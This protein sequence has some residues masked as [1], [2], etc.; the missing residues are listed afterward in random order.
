MSRLVVVAVDGARLTDLGGLNSIKE[1]GRL[2]V[3]RGIATGDD[4]SGKD[5]CRIGG[6]VA[7]GVRVCARGL[8]V[9]VGVRGTAGAVRCGAAT[10]DCKRT[11]LTLVTSTI[12][13]ARGNGRS[14]GGLFARRGGA[15]GRATARQTC[16]QTMWNTAQFRKFV[17]LR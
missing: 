16:S 5:V 17:S 14:T 3:P 4:A 13:L 15:T 8:S 1:S 2:D 12:V 10:A 11:G 7:V 9:D 6:D